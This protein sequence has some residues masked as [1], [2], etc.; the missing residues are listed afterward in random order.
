MI[1]RDKILDKEKVCKGCGHLKSDGIKPLHLGC[2]PDGNYI[3][4]REYLKNSIYKK[5]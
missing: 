1:T 3:P 5:L 2:C 4:L